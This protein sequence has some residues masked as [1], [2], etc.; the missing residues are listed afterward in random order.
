MKFVCLS[1][2]NETDLP[3]STQPAKF[4]DVNRRMVLGFRLFGAGRHA[5]ERFCSVLN[6]P[7]TLS[8]DAFGLH[9]S[10]IHSAVM[11]EAKAEF[12]RAALE[13][14]TLHQETDEA[15]ELVD[16]QVSGDGTW[17]RRGYSSLYGCF[18]IISEETG[19]VLDFIVLSKYCKACEYWS[20]K[21]QTSDEYMEWKQKHDS[22]CD[23]NFD[24]SAKAMEAEGILQLFSRS[25]EELGLRYTS[26]ISDGDSA[27]YRAV[28]EAKPYGEGVEVTKKECMGHIQKR[29]GTALR[30][31]VVAYK[32]QVVNGRKGIGGKG[33][34]T[35]KVIDSIQNY[36]GQAIRSNLHDLPGAK[37]AVQ[38]ILLH[39]SSTDAKPNHQLCPKGSDSWCGW[40][41]DVA[42]GTSAYKHKQKIPENLVKILQPTFDRLSQD[43]VLKTAVEGLTQNANEALHQLVWDR[44]PKQGF[45]G[46]STVETAAGLAALEFNRGARSLCG[47]MSRLG[48]PAGKHSKHA[49][50]C[51]D[52]ERIYHAEIKHREK[53]KKRRRKLRAIRKGLLVQ[54]ENEEPAT[55][56]SGGF[57]GAELVSSTLKT[58]SASKP[59]RA[60]MCRK[61]Q[62][63]MKGHRRGVDCTT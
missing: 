16:V 3:T 37:Q 41:R 38:A 25:V 6:M 50:A 17:M 22:Q 8:R 44:C 62:K 59:R 36:Y 24:K 21:D 11:D 35:L 30:N 19:C 12:Q 48:V 27:S 15:S 32:N 33:R 53:R 39:M 1:C 7:P 57:I 49:F 51:H 45:A 18:F 20:K 47:V 5:Q 29:M 60:P 26:L 13:L 54:Q 63:P 23:I 58:S 55:Y 52:Q 34:L 56:E 28:L 31:L 43:D 4:Y 42:N 10:K 46:R 9:R 14:Q 2:G 40:Q 61:C